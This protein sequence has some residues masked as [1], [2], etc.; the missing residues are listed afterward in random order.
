MDWL[1]GCCLCPSR[2]KGFSKAYLKNRAGRTIV[3]SITAWATKDCL[4]A[5]YVLK[6]RGLF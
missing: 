1:V 5:G 4:N 2:D 3:Q 6:G